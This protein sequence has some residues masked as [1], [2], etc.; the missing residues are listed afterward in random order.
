MEIIP[1]AKL[2]KVR[3]SVDSTELQDEPEN[4]A[5]RGGIVTLGMLASNRT[6]NESQR[7]RRQS[8][9]CSPPQLKHTVNSTPHPYTENVHL[10][11]FENEH[12]LEIDYDEDLEANHEQENTGQLSDEDV[13]CISAA[14]EDPLHSLST[15]LAEE[16]GGSSS[17]HCNATIYNEEEEI[18]QVLEWFR[19]TFT[20]I[21]KHGRVTLRDLKHAA[22]EYEVSTYVD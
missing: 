6:V 3:G 14:E 21:G 5:S 1:H 17:G 15:T 9:S 2:I 11:V 12:S 18:P 19:V 22:T 13:E 10:N 7:C 16:G 8:M 4:N 20:R